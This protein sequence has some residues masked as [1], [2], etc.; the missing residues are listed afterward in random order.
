VPN[1][2][3]LR[4][5]LDIDGVMNSYG[6]EHQDSLDPQKVRWL[7][8]LMAHGWGGR[9]IEVVFN[10]AWNVHDLDYMKKAFTEAG[11]RYPDQL[12]GQTNSCG[13]GGDPVRDY[14]IDNDL[15]GTPFI[16]IDDGT[17]NYGE[18][19]CR[20]IRCD[21]HRGFREVEYK[22]ASDL[23]WKARNPNEPRDRR[24][25]VDHLVEHTHWLATKNPWLDD[26]QRRAAVAA[27][28]DLVAHCLLVPDF[29]EAALLVKP[30]EVKPPA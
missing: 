22:A 20:L 14:L 16:I 9:H 23:T 13:G 18:M 7:S 11:F 21:G 26:V 2:E 8:K 10:T 3:S 17:K 27:N 6:G 5:F 28:L 29:L 15:V 24:L 25:A 19:W 12:T 30:P 1:D 4:I